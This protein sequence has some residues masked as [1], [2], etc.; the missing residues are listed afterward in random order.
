MDYLVGDAFDATS[1]EVTA[2]YEDGSTRVI[3]DYV[4]KGGQDLTAE[5]TSV[6]ISY[7][8]ENVT[9]S[10]TVNITV[11]DEENAETESDVKAEVSKD[12]ADGQDNT[13]TSKPEEKTSAASEE[14]NVSDQPE[15]VDSQE[16]APS[17][18][19]NASSQSENDNKPAGT[20]GEAAPQS[21]KDANTEDNTNVN[22][23]TT[24]ETT[25]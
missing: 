1:M 24:A 22:P 3:D 8:E 18:E 14:A 4:I 19:N 25:E 2:A 13:E 16:S 10:C 23:P 11:T 9:K 20:S 15:N 17:D 5:T 7:T 12:P 6:K 21:S